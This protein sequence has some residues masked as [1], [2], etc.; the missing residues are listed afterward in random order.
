MDAKV[1]VLK[2]RIFDPVVFSCNQFEAR[3]N[4]RRS[5]SM[6]SYLYFSLRTLRQTVRYSLIFKNLTNRPSAEAIQS[7][8]AK[9]QQYGTLTRREFQLKAINK[10][11][12]TV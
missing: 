7:A 1:P 12:A 11:T 2:R 8:T 4:Y 6:L 10:K 3:A 5:Q 9:K